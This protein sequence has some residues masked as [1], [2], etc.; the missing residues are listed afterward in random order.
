MHNDAASEI[1][2]FHLGMFIQQPAKNAVLTPH[3]VCRWEVDGKHPKNTEKHHRVKF[4]AFSNSA[5]GERGSDD[6]EGELVNRPDI[7]RRPVGV[8]AR[9]VSDAG[10]ESV[11]HAAKKRTSLGKAEA[12]ATNPPDHSDCASERQALGKNA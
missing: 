6:C 9:F 7:V 10:K 2:C 5:D 8:W 3:H 12:V 11:T 1:D 4:H